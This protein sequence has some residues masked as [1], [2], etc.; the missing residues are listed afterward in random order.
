MQAEYR[1]VQYLTVQLHVQA[2]SPI[3]VNLKRQKR[4]HKT[5][6]SFLSMRNKIFLLSLFILFS[7]LALP[8]LVS[9]ESAKNLYEFF[10]GDFPSFLVRK[11]IA[12]KI[13]ITD[14]R[15]TKDQNQQ[16]LNWFIYD[17][18]PLLGGVDTN[19]FENGVTNSSTSVGVTSTLV[20]SVNSG[21]QYALI[22]NNSTS[23]AVWLSLEDAAIENSGIRLNPSDGEFEID[24]SN[25]FVGAVYG[26]TNSTSTL[27]VVEK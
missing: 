4:R 15:G 26:I 9:G 11:Q 22:R 8:V 1:I 14:Y 19:R 7:F 18:E 13:G 27:T 17:D 12:R 6:F 2:R 23:T 20:L 16:L 3:A 21:R 24:S 5:A 10:G 25:L